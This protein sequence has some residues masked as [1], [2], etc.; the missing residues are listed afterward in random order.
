MVELLLAQSMGGAPYCGDEKMRSG[1]SSARS[2]DAAPCSGDEMLA[3]ELVLAWAIRTAH[4]GRDT[5]APGRLPARSMAADPLYGIELDLI[6]K[7]W[8][9]RPKLFSLSG[10]EPPPF[11][12]PLVGLKS[13]LPAVKVLSTTD[14][15]SRVVSP[16]TQSVALI[17]QQLVPVV[18]HRRKRRRQM[19]LIRPLF[20]CNS[21]QI[22]S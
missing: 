14:R 1:L 12:L 15:R 3:S 11:E 7:R 10:D 9:A 13:T 6:A 5:V 16:R 18:P 22:M 8:L 19:K 17:S 21:I 20:W 2:T 4:G